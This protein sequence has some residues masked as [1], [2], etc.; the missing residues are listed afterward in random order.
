[1]G[2][3]VEGEMVAIHLAGK[4]WADLIGVA[5]DG[6]DGFD[7]L[8]EELVEVFGA[9][10]GDVDSDFPHDLD[11]ERMNVAGRI[12]AGALDIENVAGGLTKD[13]FGKMAAAGVAGAK[14]ED[15][16]FHSAGKSFAIGTAATAPAVVAA[17]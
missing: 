10:I 4:G 2:G 13:A 15:G 8:I 16:G 14:D 3:V 9:V 12:G 5:A 6:D 7:G 1:M 17:R 11:G